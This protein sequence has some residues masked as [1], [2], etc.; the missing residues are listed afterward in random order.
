MPKPETPRKKRLW[1]KGAKD[2]SREELRALGL[3]YGESNGMRPSKPG[4]GSQSGKISV[5]SMKLQYMEGWHGEAVS[6]V[7]GVHVNMGFYPGD[8]KN[9]PPLLRDILQRLSGKIDRW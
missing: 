6:G 7:N 4:G 3:N 5:D 1:G 8:G 9:C 2:L